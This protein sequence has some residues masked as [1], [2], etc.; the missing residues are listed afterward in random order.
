MICI[1]YIYRCDN[2]F[3]LSKGNFKCDGKKDCSDGLDENNCGE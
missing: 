2:G 3:C 1:E